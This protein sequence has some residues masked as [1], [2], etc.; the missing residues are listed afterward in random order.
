VHVCL[1]VLTGRGSVYHHHH[2]DDADEEEI[3]F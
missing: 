1:L 2:H 3:L